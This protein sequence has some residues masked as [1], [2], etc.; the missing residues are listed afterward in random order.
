ML[1]RSSSRYSI[2]STRCTAIVA[3]AASCSEVAAGLRSHDRA[4]E[5]SI[6]FVTLSRSSAWVITV[7][8]QAIMLLLAGAG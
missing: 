7:V 2:V 8:T 5:A 4:F 1:R 3:I 6:P